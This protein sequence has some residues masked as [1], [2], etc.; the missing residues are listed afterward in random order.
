[1]ETMSAY[2]SYVKRTVSKW[3]HHAELPGSHG[4]EDGLPPPVL[5]TKHMLRLLLFAKRELKSRFIPNIS[6]LKI[7]GD[8]RVVI[9]GDTHGQLADF[10]WIL[11]SHGPPSSKNIYVLNG[12]V[13][14][15]GPYASEILTLVW[16]Y[17]LA[18]PGGVYM[19]RGNHENLDMNVRGFHE[20]GGFAAE[21]G[22]KYGSAVFTLI[23]ET[24]NQLPLA[25][26]VNEQILIV[27]GG[28]PRQ[29]GGR[30]PLAQLNAID[31]HRAVPASAECS[32]DAL[33]FDAMWADPSETVAGV[34]PSASRGSGCV[35]FG[36]DVTH[37]FC[38]VNKIRMIVRSHE[39]PK[40]LTGVHICHGGRLVTVFS[41]SN[42]C[43]R[44]DNTGGTMLL[45]P[46][47]DYQA[48][49]CT[50]LSYRTANPP[51]YPSTDPPPPVP[52]ECNRK[53]HTARL[54][55]PYSS[56]ATRPC[57]PLS[58]FPFSICHRTCVFSTPSLWSTGR[59]PSPSS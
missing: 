14:D 18:C 35:T 38:E 17:M 33:F 20:G 19:N 21:V 16:G 59:P 30:V 22:A 11:R 28:L 4:R 6:E 10:L 39:V 40:T 34:G 24:F 55:N 57:Y 32:H 12:D 1:M 9:V 2:L 31:R 56:H 37:A 47:F 29:D 46:S 54:T 50:R 13:A 41:A 48:S 36:A 27:H 43:G 52:Y 58:P 45:M 51:H 26:R 25:T 8:Q 53:S 44:I 42:Y 15:R 7:Q 23:Q 3:E 49:R 5:P